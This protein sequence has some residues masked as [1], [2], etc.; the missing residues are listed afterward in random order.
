MYPNLR[1]DI[2]A[3]APSRNSFTR[4]SRLKPRRNM[5][6]GELRPRVKTHAPPKTQTCPGEETRKVDLAEPK[7]L[8]VAN[9]CTSD[10][11]TFDFFP[12]S[13]TSAEQ[14]TAALP[15][16]CPACTTTT[17]ANRIGPRKTA[18]TVECQDYPDFF[19]SALKVVTCPGCVRVPP[20]QR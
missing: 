12:A 18:D 14:P 20:H 7:F 4:N 9:A 16:R 11:D 15:A 5:A 2:Q 6:Q 13:T 19:L 3:I 8:V 10:W 17:G 1:V